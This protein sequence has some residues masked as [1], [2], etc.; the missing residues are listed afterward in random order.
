[1]TP[2]KDRILE[3]S[4]RF[5]STHFNTYVKKKRSVLVHTI[6]VLLFTYN[7]YIKLYAT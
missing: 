1:M 4:I 5:R 3:R 2:A 6:L 7:L